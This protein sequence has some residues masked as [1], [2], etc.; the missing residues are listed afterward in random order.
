[1]S[2][3]IFIAIGSLLIITVLCLPIFLLLVRC[4]LTMRQQ[5]AK[6]ILALQHKINAALEDETI[7]PAPRQ[8]FSIS[9]EEASL[10]TSLQWPRLDT[11]AKVGRQTPEKYRILAKLAAQGMDSA[12]IA[13]ILGISGVE[14]AQLLS[15]CHMAEVGH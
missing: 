8:P 14:A 9:L 5:Q 10:T 11:M 12:Q 15:L 2:H 13:A 6:R 1:M 7:L 3:L 4:Q